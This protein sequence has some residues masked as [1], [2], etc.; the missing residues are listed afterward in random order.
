M[1]NVGGPELLIIFLVALV[2]LGPAKLP[3]AART[4]AK[5]VGEARKLSSGFQREFKQALEDPVGSAIADAEKSDSPPTD[6][7]KVAQPAPDE[8]P[9]RL[10]RLPMEQKSSFDLPDRSDEPPSQGDPSAGDEDTG[11]TV[12]DTSVSDT[13][14]PDAES[15][16]TTISEAEV[17]HGEPFEAP[18]VHPEHDDPPMQSD[19]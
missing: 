19:R 10:T 3:E 15:P 16:D 11:T 13:A 8:E 4:M 18:E 5:L 14:T 9:P 6:V 12:S 17:E 1:F 7:T 2:V